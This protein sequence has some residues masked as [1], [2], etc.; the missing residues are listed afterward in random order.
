MT[1]TFVVRHPRGWALG[2]VTDTAPAV[3]S[4]GDVLDALRRAGATPAGPAGGERTSPGA[5]P[6][7][8]LAPSDVVAPVWRWVGAVTADGVVIEGNDGVERVLDQDDLRL[9]DRLDGPRVV[10]E[11]AELTGVHD[12]AARLGDLA[13]AG[14][15]RTLAPGAPEPW[16]LPGPDDV[17]VVGDLGPDLRLPPEDRRCP[18]DPARIGVHAV[19][20]ERVGPALALGMLTASAR[21]WRGGALGEHYDIRRPETPSEFLGA[22]AGGEGPAV[23]LCSNYLWSLDHNLEVARRAKELRPGLV[24]VHGGP[25]TPKYEDDAARFLETHGDVADVLV[26][27][28]GEHTLC[29][30]LEALA[31]TLPA[32]DRDR[33]RDV[34]GLTFRDPVDGAVVRTAEPERVADLDALPSPYLTG[35]F[36]HIDPGAWPFAVS[37]ETNRGCPY[38]CTFCDWGSATLSRIRKFSAERVLAE[39]EWVAAR[40]I[41]GL[42]LCDANFGILARDVDL[43]RGLAD[44]R[45]RT[46]SPTGL[47]FTPPKN[48]TRHITRIFDEVMDAG[49][50]ISTAISLQSIDE[51]TLAAVD[52]SNISTDHYLA[53]A[54]DLRRRGHPLMGDLLLGLPGQTFESY[55][56]D[57]QFFVDHQIMARTWVLKVLPNSPLNEPGY[58]ARFRLRIDD[59]GLVTSTAQLSPAERDRALALR[60]AEIIANR[61]GVLR[62]VGWFLHWDHDITL[63]ALLDHLLAV[64]AATPERFPL[65]TWLCAQFDLHP[66]APVGW[67]AFYGEVGRLLAEDFGLDPAAS[68]LLTVLRLQR[69]LMPAPGRRLPQTVELDHDYERYHRE[70]SATLL[71]TGRASTPPRPLAAYPPATFTVTGDPLQLCELGLHFSGDSRDLVFEGD[72]AIGQNTANELASPLMVRLPVFSGAAPRPVDATDAALVG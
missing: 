53:M 14:R 59:Q 65:L 54:A 29:M 68:D 35:E 49:F 69:A 5:S 37:I 16:A 24:V 60:R 27:G 3:A 11:L 62:H 66:T 7:V 22:L 8:P 70:G 56:R 44:I 28:E 71:T 10:R 13:A 36:D 72:F 61:L 30:L 41:P 43:A 25:S 19:W 52:R 34:P 12:A 63:T 42:Q 67:R 31:P 39:F 51:Q 45:R 9:L 55:R 20:Q 2:A 26:R 15:L 48:T 57:L 64:T 1:A 58:R 18:T 4:L 38:G 33:L 46:G 23:L 32:L 40:G 21:A 50:L 6:V 17:D 47:G